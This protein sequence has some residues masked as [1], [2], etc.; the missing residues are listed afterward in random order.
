MRAPSGRLHS[1]S[2]AGRNQD[3]QAHPD[4]VRRRLFGQEYLFVNCRD[5]Q[6]QATLPEGGAITP[7]SGG[8]RPK[9]NGVD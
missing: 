2:Q 5:S 3:I 7:P 6:I 8:H 9:S 4:S 1:W